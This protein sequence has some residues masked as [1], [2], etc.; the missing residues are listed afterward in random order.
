MVG[1]FTSMRIGS[2]NALNRGIYG[3]DVEHEHCRWVCVGQ[4]YAQRPDIYHSVTLV[5][6]KKETEGRLS[7]IGKVLL[8]NDAFHLCCGGKRF[9]RSS[10][11][12][13]ASSS[14][15]SSLLRISQR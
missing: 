10:L 5:K 6:R 11:C 1:G 12:L 3:N 7:F 13:P 9:R 2:K 4:S 15:L 8:K 14:L